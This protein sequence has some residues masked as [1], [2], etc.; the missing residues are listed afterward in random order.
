MEG[1]REVSG[2]SFKEKN[3]LYEILINF[4]MPQ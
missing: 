3:R 2:F 1:I 4:G